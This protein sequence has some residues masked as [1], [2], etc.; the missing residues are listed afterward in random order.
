MTREEKTEDRK[1]FPESEGN[2]NSPSP[3]GFQRVWN[4]ECGRWTS[5]PIAEAKNPNAGVKQAFPNGRWT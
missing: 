1:L 5:E 2:P 4:G 3:E